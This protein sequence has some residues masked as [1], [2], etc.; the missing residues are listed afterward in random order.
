MLNYPSGVVLEGVAGTE[1]Q[2]EG[3]A[4]AF[5]EPIQK[6]EFSWDHGQ[7]WTTLETPDNDPQYWTYWRMGFTPPSEGAYLLD[8][9]TTSL[10]AD[11]TERV[12]GVNT[13]FLLNVK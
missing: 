4:D 10:Q 11:G 13:Q 12:N 6:I 2:I 3:F 5:D 7:T 9:R 8:I 1:V